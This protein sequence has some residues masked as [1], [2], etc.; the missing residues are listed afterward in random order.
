M[1]AG[2]GRRRHPLLA[3]NRERVVKTIRAAAPGRLPRSRCGPDRSPG[4]AASN[5]LAGRPTIISD[6]RD[7][8]AELTDMAVLT[9]VNSALLPIQVALSEAGVPCES[10][11]TSRVLG[12]TG[13][14]TA[15]AYLR[16]GVRPERISRRDIEDTIR[17]PSRGIAP[18]VVSM[19]TKRSHTSVEEIRRLAG[20]LSG[21]DV[22]KLS[23]YADDIEMVASACTKPT[24]L[25][26][27]TI[28]VELGLGETMDVLD[29]SRDEPDRSTH[30]DDL[31]ALESVAAF[32]PD[33]ATF[34]TWLRDVLERPTPDGPAVLLVHRAPHQG[35]RVGSG[36]RLRR[37]GRR[38]PPPA[39]RRRRR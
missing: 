30:N 5:W 32:H 1:S 14:R 24:A 7:G 2:G 36:D 4:S 29:A 39:G 33:V 31:V 15:F 22:P 9:R 26:L 8:G 20:S 23:A 37:L 28:R 34:G 35:S 17:R 6:W 27:R 12:R 18:N 38:L 16:M 25:A 21:R 10:T 19:L 13:V 11:L 3:Y